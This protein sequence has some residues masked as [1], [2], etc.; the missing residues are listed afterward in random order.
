MVVALLINS[1]LKGNQLTFF[2]KKK[3]PFDDVKC[4]E[5]QS[6]ITIWS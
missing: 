1:F 5:M 3:H 6:H 4:I 2:N